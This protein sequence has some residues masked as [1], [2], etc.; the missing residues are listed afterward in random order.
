[1]HDA[2]VLAN[3]INVLHHDSTEEE[4]EKVFKEY[5]NERLPYVM[6]A[7]NFSQSNSHL[8]GSVSELSTER[9]VEC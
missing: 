3:W 4:V 7:Y 6:Q 9:T 2:V 1:M 8:I 5:R